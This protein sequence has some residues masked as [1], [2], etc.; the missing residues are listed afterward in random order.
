VLGSV[1]HGR[2]SFLF[3]A[4]ASCLAD[5]ITRMK[6]MSALDIADQLDATLDIQSRAWIAAKEIRRLHEAN[7]YLLVA[8]LKTVQENRHLADGDNCTLIDLVRV[9][10]AN[11][12][13][14]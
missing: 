2:R 14:V 4:V 10:K 7:S 13:V 1:G 11:G 8:I 9:L 5:W 6:N 12:V 3:I